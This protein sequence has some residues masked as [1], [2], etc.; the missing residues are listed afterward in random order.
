[1]VEVESAAAHYL[2]P[3]LEGMLTDRQCTQFEELGFVRI[4][5][6]FST[7]DAAAKRAVAW[8]ELRRKYADRAR[9]IVPIE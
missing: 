5:G 4:P 3:A 1:M 7:N 9:W 6:A 2:L 8:R